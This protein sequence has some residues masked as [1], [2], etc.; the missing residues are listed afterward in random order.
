[1]FSLQVYFRAPQAVSALN[2]DVAVAPSVHGKADLHK[3]A[4]VVAKHA[5]QSRCHHAAVP[6]M[7][8]E[9]FK[10]QGFS[11][12]GQKASQAASSAA[13]QARQPFEV[14][15][16]G[17][18]VHEAQH[19]DQ[20]RQR[21]IDM[22]TSGHVQAC[23]GK[24]LSRPAPADVGTYG[25][26]EQPGTRHKRLKAI[27]QTGQ[28]AAGTAKPAD[29]EVL[30]EPSVCGQSSSKSREVQ[31]EANR[32]AL[33]LAERQSS[34]SRAEPSASGV[35]LT[36]SSSLGSVWDMS[37]S[38]AECK[39]AV[40]K[41]SATQSGLTVAQLKAR[42]QLSLIGRCI[43]ARLSGLPYQ[44]KMLLALF[45]FQAVQAE[46]IASDKCICIYVG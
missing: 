42:S 11:E 34:H 33:V 31:D 29:T 30:T 4:A 27:Q 32:E 43:F 3:D 44:A 45:H 25:T 13:S 37:E 8:V 15:G 39:P 17:T 40:P 9:G 26:A 23:T 20:E 21:R 46:A 14:T 2:G 16:T 28:E 18:H 24:P 10:Q 38:D 19:T 5:A 41:R 1:M 22:P 7:E 36:C 6:Q 12:R 35:S